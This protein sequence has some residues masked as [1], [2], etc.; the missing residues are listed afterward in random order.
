MKRDTRRTGSWTK[1]GAHYYA[2]VRLGG[3]RR[4]ESRMTGVTDDASA[5][6]RAAQIATVADM[7]VG[8]RRA[9]DVREFARN[10]GACTTAKQVR[11][12]IRAAE[13]LVAQAV[14][15]AYGAISFEAFALRWTSGQL[16]LDHP[17]H[18]AKKQPEGDANILKNRINPI[19]GDVPLVAF[20]LEDADRVMRALPSPPEISRAYRRAVAQVVHRVLSLAVYPAKIIKASPLPKGWLP[21]IGKPK[22]KSFLYPKEEAALLANRSVDVRYRMLVGFLTREGCRKTEARLMTWDD[23]DLENGTVTLDRNK[24]DSPRSWPLDP[25][26]VRALR[27]WKKKHGGTGPFAGLD[28]AHLGE[29]MRDW[30]RASGVTRPQLFQESDQRIHFRAHDTRSTFVTLSLANDKSEAWVMRRTAHKSS[31]MIARYTVAAANARELGLGPLV[32]LDRAIPELRKR[33]G[34]P[35]TNELKRAGGER[36]RAAQAAA[37]GRLGEERVKSLGIKRAKGGAR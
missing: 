34:V 20:T 27:V 31:A 32:P 9:F 37:R 4:I 11:P 8:A 29:H 30:L 24:T 36:G 18:V 3:K 23:F 19:V 2:R 17:D 14:A 35:T 21:K 7:L 10:I 6:E 12:F 16:H 26:V 28:A 13:M 33:G 22:A 15:P 25:G 5:D 1:R